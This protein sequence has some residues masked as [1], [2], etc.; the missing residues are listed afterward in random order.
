MG[1][2]GGTRCMTW[3]VRLRSRGTVW[4]WVDFEDVVTYICIIT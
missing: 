1:L 4:V 2:M 3:R